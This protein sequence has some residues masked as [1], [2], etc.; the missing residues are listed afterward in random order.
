[1]LGIFALSAAALSSAPAGASPLLTGAMVVTVTG[2]SPYA[3]PDVFGPYDFEDGLFT[4]LINDYPADVTN[5]AL[6]PFTGTR[7]AQCHYAISGAPDHKD[8]NH[9]FDFDALGLNLSH[10]FVRCYF[11]FD[12]ASC[13]YTTVE[14]IARKLIYVKSGLGALDWHF[15]VGGWDFE[16]ASSV[17]DR[18][19]GPEINSTLG[20][21]TR[22]ILPLDVYRGI[23]LE[24]QLNTPGVADGLQRLWVYNP[25]GTTILTQT[26]AGIKLRGDTASPTSYLRRLEFGRQVDRTDPSTTV[27]ELRWLD[28]PAVSTQRIGPQIGAGTSGYTAWG[29]IGLNYRST[30]GYVTDP[31]GTVFVSNDVYPT[32]HRFAQ[33][34]ILYEGRTGTW[35]GSDDCSTSVDPRLAGDSFKS[36]TLTST[37]TIT[38]D[39]HAPLGGTYSLRMALGSATHTNFPNVEVTDG[40]GGAVLF[41]ISHVAGTVA[42]EF[43]DAT[44]VKRTSAAD[45]VT[46]NAARTI[47]TTGNALVL[48]FKYL[49]PLASGRNGIAHLQLTRIG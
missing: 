48:N 12:S 37:A 16:L 44:D 4:G 5:V 47:V 18:D 29:P 39:L 21:D 14:S 15:T 13:I 30:L 42:E 9:D 41:T 40:V 36:H 22:Y 10:F 8:S 38:I 20:L 2:A 46:N 49:S 19:N 31:A 1:M 35:G 11:Y 27:D 7:S 3:A 25:D 45:W 32:Q 23:E 33:D 26:W 43:Y 17:V 6:H 24:V 34:M 28:A